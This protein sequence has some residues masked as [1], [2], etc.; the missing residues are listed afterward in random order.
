MYY[1]CITTQDNI[2]LIWSTKKANCALI[3]LCTLGA[4]VPLI[5][6]HRDAVPRSPPFSPPPPPPPSART[7]LFG[8]HSLRTW[9]VSFS[10]LLIGKSPRF[11]LTSEPN[12][13]TTNI[14]IRSIKQF[15]CQMQTLLGKTSFGH[16]LN[17]H[18]PDPN[19]G[20]LVLFFGRQNSLSLQKCGEGGGRYIN[21]LKNS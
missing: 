15:I 3:A 19:S 12:L 5:A 14:V 11:C 7:C 17:P 8:F 6:L 16:H 1:K 9:V 18:P 21:N 2:D 13:Q 10:L 4:K 20:N